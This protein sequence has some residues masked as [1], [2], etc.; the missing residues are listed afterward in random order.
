MKVGAKSTA[1]VESAAAFRPASRPP[2]A[3]V[4]GNVRKGA[5]R[6][7]SI[8]KRKQRSAS[9]PSQRTPSVIR[10]RPN[11]ESLLC[12]ER[13][14]LLSSPSPAPHL[15]VESETPAAAHRADA[16]N[17]FTNGVCRQRSRNA[18][19]GT[20]KRCCIPPRND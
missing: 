11:E 17:K 13:G 4:Q 15:R 2:L 1:R 6:S 19:P 8:K 5:G 14:P 9:V 12:D 16:S 18:F 7:D 10:I 3:P 20:C